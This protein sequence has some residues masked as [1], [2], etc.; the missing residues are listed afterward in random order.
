MAG[1]SSW[2]YPCEEA[3]HEHHLL[4][5]DMESGMHFYVCR[6]SDRGW[7]EP[8]TLRPWSV[9]WKYGEGRPVFRWEDVSGWRPDPERFPGDC[10][11]NHGELP[12]GSYEECNP[13]CEPCWECYV[14][15]MKNL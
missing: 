8:L 4:Y 12:P 10:L 1:K 6:E 14:E 3:E 7:T 9:S 11:C 13:D 15:T 5:V 2:L